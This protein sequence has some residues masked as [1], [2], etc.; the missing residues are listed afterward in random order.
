MKRTLF[1]LLLL[2]TIAIGASGQSRGGCAPSG[3]LNFIC[4]LQAPEDLVLI[5]NTRWADPG[6]SMVP[7]LR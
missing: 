3:G 1:A 6:V 5:P 4:G 2:I 7:K